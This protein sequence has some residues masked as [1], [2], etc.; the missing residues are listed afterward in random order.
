MNEWW[1]WEPHA[2]ALGAAALAVHV[3][4]QVGYWAG[5]AAGYAEGY[6]AGYRAGG[7]TAARAATHDLVLAPSILHA[8]DVAKRTEAPR[9][10]RWERQ[11]QRKGGQP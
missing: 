10:T 8:R 7:L 6:D 2:I 4:R 5:P 1:Q 3:V 9:W 11:W